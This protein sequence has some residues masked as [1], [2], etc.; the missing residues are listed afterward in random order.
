MA[1]HP[2]QRQQGDG[3]HI[4]T[5]AQPHRRAGDGT[6]LRLQ[7]GD[8]HNGR[9]LLEELAQALAQGGPHN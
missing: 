6:P 9:R 7:H 5:Y 8:D 1:E 4:P 3:T 2:T